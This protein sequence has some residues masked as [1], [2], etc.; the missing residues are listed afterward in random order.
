MSIYE[1]REQRDDR[2]SVFRAGPPL[3]KLERISKLG[4]L[5]E[6]LVAERLQIHGFTNVENLNLRRHNYPF[7]DVLATKDRVRYF[8]GV[9]TRNEM[10]QGDAGLNESYNLVLIPD[11]ANAR[12]KQQ[13]KTTDQI[14]SML[15]AEVIS[16]AADLDAAPAWA[17]VSIRPRVGTY[18]AYFGLVAQLGNRRSVPMTPKACAAYR[19]LARDLTDSRVTLDLLNA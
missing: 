16:L 12:L 9:K 6:D 4:R 8:I 2:R 11:S 14:T 7:G 1:V 3:L 18:S 17:T 10:R 5:G 19:C 13:G 15:L